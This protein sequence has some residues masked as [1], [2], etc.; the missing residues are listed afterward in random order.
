MMNRKIS[1]VILNRNMDKYNDIVVIEA[2]LYSQIYIT[3]TIFVRYSGW[4]WAIRWMV[5]NYWIPTSCERS[6]KSTPT[7][8]VWNRPPSEL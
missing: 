1:T 7:A 4:P 2:L 5:S 6:R 8:T 3:G